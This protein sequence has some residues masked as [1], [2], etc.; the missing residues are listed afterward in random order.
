MLVKQNEGSI[1][2]SISI[3]PTVILTEFQN[4]KLPRVVYTETYRYITR[5]NIPRNIKKRREMRFKTA[6]LRIIFKLT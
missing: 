6:I 3:L 4:L 1:S 5:F 2:A